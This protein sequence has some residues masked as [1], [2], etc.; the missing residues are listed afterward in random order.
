MQPTD[1]TPYNTGKVLIGSRY[2]PPRR[3]EYSADAELLQSALLNLGPRFSDRVAH[4]L[5]RPGTW[6][7][8]AAVLVAVLFLVGFR[9]AV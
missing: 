3:M 9:G 8:V 4:S 2:E 1:R 7:V 6:M 5:F